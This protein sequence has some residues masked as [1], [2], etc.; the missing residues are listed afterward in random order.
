MKPVPKSV[1]LEPTL[2]VEVDYL[3]FAGGE[4]ANVRYPHGEYA[5]SYGGSTCGSPIAI[6][7]LKAVIHMRVGKCRR[8]LPFPVPVSASAPP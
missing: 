7:V 8:R 4:K 6:A 3:A 2:L 1:I 5:I